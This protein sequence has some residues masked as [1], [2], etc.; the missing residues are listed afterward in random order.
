MSNPTV[1]GTLRSASPVSILLL[2]VSLAVSGSCRNEAA[3]SPADPAAPGVTV[4][5]PAQ[6]EAGADPDAAAP[7]DAPERAETGTE[8]DVAAPL[9]AVDEMQAVGGTDVAESLAKP[10]DA[11]PLA[12]P[13]EP[14]PPADV[15]AAAS[16]SANPLAGCTLCHVD[17]EDEY[18]GSTHYEEAVACT[19]CHGPSEGHVADENNEIKPDELFARED[20]DRLCGACHDCP[21][22]KPDKPSPEPKVCTD[23]HGPHDIAF[24][25]EKG[26][27][28][29]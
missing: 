23:C 1:S 8:P 7:I 15:M 24:L 20:A 10:D 17:I 25:A 29:E 19:K 11:A 22:P 21:R 12:E 18:I 16:S 28:D 26:P 4:T 5:V 2:L 6:I 14:E 13:D 9:V 3:D 27:T